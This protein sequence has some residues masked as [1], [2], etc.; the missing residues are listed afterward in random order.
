MSGAPP[1][2]LLLGEREKGGSVPER[3]K[4]RENGENIPKRC[5]DIQGRKLPSETLEGEGR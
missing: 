5:R 3:Q 2:S 1:V 4:E